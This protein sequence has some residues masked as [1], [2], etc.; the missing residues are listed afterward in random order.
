ME[1]TGHE[2]PHTRHSCDNK[3]CWNPEHL[4]WGSAGDNMQDHLKR[5]GVYRKLDMAT[6]HLI[7]QRVSAGEK[8]AVIARELG[9]HRTTV[10][11]I[12]N[13]RMWEAA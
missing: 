1:T 6:A 4:E 5:G 12:V 8:Q 13:G 9:L 7:K 3:R 10:G 11:A 2:E